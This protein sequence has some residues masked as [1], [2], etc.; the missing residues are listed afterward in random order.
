MTRK[1]SRTRY[2]NFTSFQLLTENFVAV[3][4]A[5]SVSPARLS[6]TLSHFLEIFEDGLEDAEHDL[7][8]EAVPDG[9]PG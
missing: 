7:E 6:A 1:R 3:P 9:F 2:F 4:P 8:Q 5:F